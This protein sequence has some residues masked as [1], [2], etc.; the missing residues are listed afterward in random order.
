MVVEVVQP[1]TAQPSEV[2]QEL[3]QGVGAHGELGLSN[4]PTKSILAGADRA[5]G[6]WHPVP[7]W[8]CFPHQTVR[9]LEYC[10]YDVAERTTEARDVAFPIGHSEC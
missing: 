10:R 4:C 7:G 9:Q 5:S 8:G 1:V 3:G 6:H 2:Q